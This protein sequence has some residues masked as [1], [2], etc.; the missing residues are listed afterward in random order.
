M[1]PGDFD[2]QRDRLIFRP[3]AN[4]E[5][6]LFLYFSVCVRAVNRVFERSQAALARFLAE[7]ENR[8]LA[9]FAVG[10][11][12][13][14]VNQEIDCGVLILIDRGGE[15]DLILDITMGDRGVEA[16]QRRERGAVLAHTYGEGPLFAHLP[17]LV[18]V[19]DQVGQEWRL[20]PDL[21]EP[22]DGARPNLLDRRL[23]DE[24][25]QHSRHARVVVQG[26]GHRRM[27]G[28]FDCLLPFDERAQQIQALFIAG[29]SQPVDSIA[30]VF[31][32]AVEIVNLHP[33]NRAVVRLAQQEDAQVAGLARR[34][35][36]NVNPVISRHRIPFA[37]PINVNRH[38][39]PH[40]ERVGRPESSLSG[41]SKPDR[42]VYPASQIRP[43]NRNESW[44][45]RFGN[46]NGEWILDNSDR[47]NRVI[48]H[49]GQ[50]YHRNQE[51]CS[52][53]H[54]KYL[55]QCRANCQFALINY[56]RISSMNLTA[57]G[58]RL[59]PS[60]KIAFF[61]ISTEG[62]LFAICISFRNAAF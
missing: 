2:E 24:I 9:G 5:D 38:A 4:G 26:D 7:P 28:D 11:L 32:D 44:P 23:L 17:G 49:T 43:I 10:V 35:E 19:A 62:S 22:E 34:I 42:R 57:S 41:A 51:K 56:L 61:F 60:Q 37:V 52:G 29:A 50:R 25:L 53:D 59:C 27:L 40:V 21:A 47:I 6:G 33:R 54:L 20:A 58:S 16:L 18:L 55:L 1:G 12:A 13:G 8:L 39:G 14:D 3:L 45:L 15:D 31:T 46:G 30:A 48:L 36:R